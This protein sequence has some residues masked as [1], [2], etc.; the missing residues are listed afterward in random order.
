M[1]SLLLLS[2]FVTASLSLVSYIYCWQDIR[3]GH[4]HIISLRQITSVMD[5]ERLTRMFG[6]PQPGYYYKLTPEQVHNVMKRRGWFFYSECTADIMCLLGAWM[7]MTH[8]LG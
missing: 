8:A 4:P 5:R 2:I 1:I 7:Y 6:Q 3:H